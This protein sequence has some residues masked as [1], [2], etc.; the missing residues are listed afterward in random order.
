MRLKEIF[1]LS[2]AL[3]L[4]AA[5]GISYADRILPQLLEGRMELSNQAVIDQENILTL[6][7][8]LDERVEQVKVKVAFRLPRGV[9]ALG[10]T[11]FND[12]IPYGERRSYSVRVKF[13]APVPSLHASV[14]AILPDGRTVP[15]QFTLQIPGSIFGLSPAPSEYFPAKLRG[16]VISFAPGDTVTISGRVLFFD[17]ND[18]IEK[19]IRWVGIKLISQPEFKVLGKAFTDHDGRYSFTVSQSPPL[20]LYIEIKF[21]NDVL[22]ITDSTERTYKFQSLPQTISQTGDYTIDYTFDSAN[23]YRMLGF[24]H[25]TIMDAHDF[26]S[27]KLN[28]SRRRIRVEYPSGDWPYYHY[29]WWSDGTIYDESITIPSGWEWKRTTIIHEYGHAVMSALCDYNTH[30]LPTK[31]YEGSHR[32]TTIS[33]RGFAITEGWAEFFEALVDD[34]AFNVTYWVNSQT[35]NIEENRW[36]TGDPMGEGGNR[37][38]S[39]VEGAIASVFWDI[40]DT[41]QSHDH[42][43]KKDDDLL[44]GM[45]VQLW[46]V[47]DEVMPGDILQLWKGWDQLGFGMREELAMIY[48]QHHI[49]L[50]DVT[51]EITEPSEDTE[52]M[53]SYVIRWTDDAPGVDAQ[54]TLYACPDGDI[55]NSFQITTG[56]SEDDETDS[57]TWDLSDVPP[58]RYLI[59]AV[60][61][62]DINPPVYAFASGYLTVHLA[63]P[64]PSISVYPSKL[65]F[66]K[67]LIGN[68]KRLILDIANKGIDDLKISSI[69]SSDP[70]VVPDISAVEILPGAR[71]EVIVEF[72]PQEQGEYQGKLT[73]ESDDPNSSAFEIAF[74]GVGIQ[75]GDVT[76][77]GKLTA[78][79]AAWVLQSCADMRDLSEDERRI[80]DVTGDGDVTP[81]DALLILK[82]IVRTVDSLH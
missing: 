79:D 32:I 1:Y 12:L 20:S 9:K 27:D 68:S 36:W 75:P 31:R 46:R 41:A 61:D 3:L 42:Q 28:W 67:V 66:G 4:A 65:F 80:A 2:T 59:Y 24:I 34:N 8:R 21:E 39:I 13:T 63:E 33:D 71:A 23:P 53:S 77:S 64:K 58:G 73:I 11:E 25:N 7:L 40:A 37:D 22:Y 70:S 17:D 50:S 18:Q 15:H 26:L 43:L 60:I 45:L 38:G 55:T 69:R 82:F 14:Y 52:A 16:E 81:Q 74:E 56:I 51:I 78:L 35:P 29:W 57:F 5:T 48:S 76:G 54:I 30:N 10:E 6:H 19:P 49:P 62:D 44:D 47:M 72:R